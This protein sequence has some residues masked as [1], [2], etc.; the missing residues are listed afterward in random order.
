VI[1]FVAE[2]V[3]VGGALWILV[4]ALGWIAVVATRLRAAGGGAPSPTS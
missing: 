2:A 4:V 3:T 1:G